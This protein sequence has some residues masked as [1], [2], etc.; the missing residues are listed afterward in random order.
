M[1]RHPFLR[2]ACLAAAISLMT[3]CNHDNGDAENAALQSS[4]TTTQ[5]PATGISSD[6]NGA[7]SNNTAVTSGLKMQF[8]DLQGNSGNITSTDLIADLPGVENRPYL[9]GFSVSLFKTLQTRQE[10]DAIKVYAR[11]DMNI[12]SIIIPSVVSS[13]PLLSDVQA[14]YFGRNTVV[15]VDAHSA[16]AHEL[17]MTELIELDDKIQVAF[18]LCSRDPM[19]V[20]SH[21]ATDLWFVI[22]KTTKP[23]EILPLRYPPNPGWHPFNPEM[24][25][26]KCS[27]LVSKDGK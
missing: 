1:S 16:I 5:Q 14:D 11:T 2:L 25:T 7:T 9:G 6:S 22:P 8:A 24:G 17:K 20:A 27:D 10:F 18:E 3:A 13:A 4:G 12:P 26:P 19:F 15:I 21:F 23:I